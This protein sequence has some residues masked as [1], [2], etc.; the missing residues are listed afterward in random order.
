MDEGMAN[1]VSQLTTGLTADTLW[2]SVSSVM[3]LVISVTLFAF[4]FWLVKKIIKKIRTGKA[5]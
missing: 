4:G 5:I 1:V 3:P 2:T